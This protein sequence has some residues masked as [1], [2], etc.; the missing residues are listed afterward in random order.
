MANVP[1]VSRQR[2]SATTLR[3]H[4]S[5]MAGVSGRALHVTSITFSS[6]EF[7]AAAV[8]CSHLDR[9]G[10]MRIRCRRVD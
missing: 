10:S 5:M 9:A 6:L 8:R 1:W 2:I 7:F 3:A 4:S